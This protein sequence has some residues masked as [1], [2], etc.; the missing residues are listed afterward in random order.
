[1]RTREIE[2][3]LRN[4]GSERGTL[5]VLQALNEQVNQMAKAISEL[6]KAC[7]LLADTQLNLTQG[8][9]GVQAQ[10]VETLRKAG[11]SVEGQSEDDLGPSTQ[12]IQ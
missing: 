2:E 8:V 1:M 7:H 10:L 6:E 9:G 5:Y 3:I 4:R 11:I 12:G